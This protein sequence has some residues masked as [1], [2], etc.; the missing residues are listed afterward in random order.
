MRFGGI[1]RLHLQSRGLCQTRSAFSLLLMVYC[2]DYISTPSIGAICSFETSLYLVTA[3]R[4]KPECYIQSD[5]YQDD[6]VRLV[7]SS[8]LKLQFYLTD[9]RKGVKNFFEVYLTML[10]VTH[11]GTR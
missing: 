6:I 9:L 2:L 8:S 7:I 3:L 5:V 11:W 1:Y 4:Y 10:Q